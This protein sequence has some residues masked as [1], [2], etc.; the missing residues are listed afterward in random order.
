[1]TGSTQEQCA[2]FC[3]GTGRNGKST[4]ID[5]I[6]DMLGDYAANIQPESLMIKPL[7]SG[8]A[9]SDIARLKGGAICDHC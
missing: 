3:Y 9:N 7:Q 1:M 2:F 5:I 8:G 4:F 6:S